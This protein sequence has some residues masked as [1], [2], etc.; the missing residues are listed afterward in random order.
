M[1]F[2]SSPPNPIEND[3]DSS[4]AS[5]DQFLA[6]RLRRR[7]TDTTV[8]GNNDNNNNIPPDD[9]HRRQGEIVNALFR[10]I[11]EKKEREAK[12]ERI[13]HTG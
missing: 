9:T 8:G 2:L 4:E 10:E 1:C 5:R 11:K 3:T 13:I 12:G 6:R 7:K